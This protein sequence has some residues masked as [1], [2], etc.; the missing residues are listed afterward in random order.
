MAEPEEQR[1]GRPGI[2]GL[3]A[4]S[5]LGLSALALGAGDRPP[6]PL[7]ASAV[8]VVRDLPPFSLVG[9][10]GRALAS[11]DL[12]GRVWV[13]SFVFTRCP[14]VC[15]AMVAQV[16]ILQG[17]LPESVLQVSFSVDP[18]HD[19]PEVLAAFAEFQGRI[20]GRWIMA[21]GE[22]EAIRRLAID[23]FGLPGKARQLHSSK[24]ALVDS[25]GRLRGTYPSHDPEAVAA[26][27]R[28][29]SL[30]LAEGKRGHDA[31]T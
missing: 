24:F 26:L 27:L 31:A 21:T 22:P 18:E 29:A 20:P 23:G 6:A 13:A 11:S 16:R 7:P 30:V 4:G 2:L 15:V 25:S 17:A 9:D 3:L 8:P 1:R 28:D 19:T 12:K 10:D 14:D 5:V